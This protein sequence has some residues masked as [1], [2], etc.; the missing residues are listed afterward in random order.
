MNQKHFTLV[1]LIIILGI[2]IILVTL[3]NKAVAKSKD[4]IKGVS[5]KKNLSELGK[6]SASYSSE[7]NNYSLPATTYPTSGD[8]VS[9]LSVLFNQNLQTNSEDFNCPSMSEE[10]RFNPNDSSNSIDRSL[11]EGSYIMNSINSFTGS[12][13]VP[14]GAQG[15]SRSTKEMLHN[16]KI[17]H[18]ASVF[19]IVDAIERPAIYKSNYHWSSDMSSL[20][21]WKETDHSLLPTTTGS[22]KRDVGYHHDNFSFNVL[23]GDGRVGNRLISQTE[24]WIATH[25]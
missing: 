11:D 18:P 9:F 20:W 14:T 8:K 17:K 6:M 5:C 22:N 2:M 7:N 10:Y 24:E 1:E 23:F 13:K 19:Y 25:N 3:F 15:W 12:P 4:E 21:S 16:T